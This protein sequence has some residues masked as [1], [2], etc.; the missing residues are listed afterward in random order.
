VDTNGKAGYQATDLVADVTGA[1]HLDA[2][3]LDSFM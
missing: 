2:F 3:S 1:K